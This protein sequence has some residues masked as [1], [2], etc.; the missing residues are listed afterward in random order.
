[1]IRIVVDSTFGL[2]K[3]F[4]EENKIKVVNLKLI[5]DGEVVDEGFEDT[6]DTF[7][8]KLENSKNFPTTSQPSPQ[9]FMDAINEIYGEDSNAE[10]FVFTISNFLS[11]TINAA[12]IAVNSFEN[13]KIKVI[14]SMNGSA[15]S[16]LLIE[17]V[18][19]LIKNNKTFEEIEQIVPIIQ[20]KTSLYFVPPTLEYLKRGGRCSGLTATL[21]NILQIKPIFNFK[22]SVLSIPKKVLGI[23]R[24]IMDLVQLIPQNLKKLYLFHVG[25]APLTEKLEERIKESGKKTPEKFAVSPVFG[26]HIGIG[27]FGIAYL[28]N[29]SI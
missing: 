25:N 1:M 13:K 28:E 7:Y 29:Y 11:G 6:W 14:D 2:P 3:K 27:T 20:S 4:T 23:G 22:Q 5:L 17:E 10:I 9:D 26:C 8:N 24:A 12:T 21:A 15:G 16:V 19:E 18:L